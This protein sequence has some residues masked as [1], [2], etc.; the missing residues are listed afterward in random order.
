MEILLHREEILVYFLNKKKLP[1]LRD[2]LFSGSFFTQI[3]QI[4][5]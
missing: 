5:L 3:N 2:L 4:E 1:D